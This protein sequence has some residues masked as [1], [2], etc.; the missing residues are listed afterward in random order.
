MGYDDECFKT[1]HYII[2]KETIIFSKILIISE[3]SASIITQT[4]VR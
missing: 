1:N 2:L 4:K 3:E